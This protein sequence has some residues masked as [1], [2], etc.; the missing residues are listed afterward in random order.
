MTKCS[1][2]KEKEE[3]K[4]GTTIIY[5]YCESCFKKIAFKPIGK[6][7]IILAKKPKND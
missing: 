1:E 4:K 5:D 3:I 6:P 7:T 2:C